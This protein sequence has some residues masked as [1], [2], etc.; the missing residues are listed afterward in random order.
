MAKR[1]TIGENPLDAV[2]Q[3]NPLDAVVP[4]LAVAGRTGR[5]PEL[6]PEV[7]KRLQELDAELKAARAEV[8]G[9]KASAGEAAS[10]KAELARLR[11]EVE[12]LKAEA[13]VV[14]GLKAEVSRLKDEL[15]QLKAAG[16]PGDLPWWMRLRKK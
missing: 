9:L 1:S 14:S 5:A 3:E 6:A 4:V 11:P 7:Q 15:A 16:G 10:L 8:A 12:Q 13:G 2:I